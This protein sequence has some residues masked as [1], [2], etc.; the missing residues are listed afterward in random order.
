M[1]KEHA[2]HLRDAQRIEDR[3]ALAADPNSSVLSFS[4]DNSP[5]DFA[6][7]VGSGAAQSPS[8]NGVVPVSNGLDDDIWGSILNDEA[9]RMLFTN[10][11]TC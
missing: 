5:S 4:S 1:E 11:R 3:S 10:I 2:Q 6:K 8:N 9:R 7:L